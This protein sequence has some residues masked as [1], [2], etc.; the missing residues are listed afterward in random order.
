ML[1]A[2]AVILLGGGIFLYCNQAKV[3][4]EP[5]N[6]TA[7]YHHDCQDDITR[8]NDAVER[9]ELQDRIELLRALS[10]DIRA[11][12][13]KKGKN[14]LFMQLKAELSGP[15]EK[16]RVLELTTSLIERIDASGEIDG[17]IKEAMS[18]ERLQKLRDSVKDLPNDKKHERLRAL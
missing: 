3:T 9:E 15:V 6:T 8:Y 11:K 12:E 2:G 17:R 10:D 1:I 16:K 14:C 5:S 13:G 18:K 7:F 4:T